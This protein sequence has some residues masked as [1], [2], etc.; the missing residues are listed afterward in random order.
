MKW[1]GAHPW[2]AGCYFGLFLSAFLAVPVMI[3]ASVW[4]GAL[5][6]I[7][8]WSVVAVLFALGLKRRWG[9]RSGAEIYP[10][11]T[12]RRIWSRTSDRFLL[13]GVVLGIASALA[14]AVGLLTGSDS[15]LVALLGLGASGWLAG[16]TWVE[17]KRRRKSD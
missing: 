13:G 1:A 10:A 5:L 17:R 9:Q 3:R 16:P 7:V 11:P 15:P 2:L 12:A 8:T 4:R 14:S 6:G